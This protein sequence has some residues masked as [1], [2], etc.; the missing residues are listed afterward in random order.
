MYKSIILIVSL[1]KFVIL[2]NYVELKEH[3]FKKL[4][5]YKLKGTIILSKEGINGTI[6]GNN[7]NIYS[8][9]AWL[10]IDARLININYNISFYNKHPFS[11]NQVKLKKEIVTLGVQNI[12]P[13]KQYGN[14]VNPENWNDLIK[15]QNILL[16]DIRNIYEIALGSFK[17]AINLKIKKFSDFTK[18]VQNFKKKKI[19]IFCTGGI[20]CEKAYSYM[21]NIG[22]K[23]VYQLKGGII[24]YLRLIP[25]LKSKWYGECFVFDSRIFIKY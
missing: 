19:A 22:F 7:I 9:I 23:K 16:L 24:E 17:G 4:V 15:K 1:Y 14:Y 2:D 8:I 25:K 6:S 21:L 5:F 10:R 12:N 3:L 13:N 20:R 18:Y 11:K